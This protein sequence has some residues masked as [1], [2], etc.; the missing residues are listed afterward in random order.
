[1]GK[2]LKPGRIVIVTNGRFAGRKA[3]CVK[4]FDDGSKA[5]AFGHCLVAGVAR[6]PLKVTRAMSKKKQAKRLRVKPFVKYVNYT[7]VMP[8][9][10]SIPSDMEPKSLINDAQ[11]DTPD[12]RC[13]AKR[14]LAAT[15]KER[16][17]TPVQTSQTDKSGS[18]KSAVNF[19][20]TKL[21][22]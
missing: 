19:L 9:R 22:F 11:M 5:R 8:T 3:V 15:F 7:H 21:R 1:M 20:K 10:Y 13:E 17:I 12:A 14:A 2:F 18:G 16:F 6:P 4:C